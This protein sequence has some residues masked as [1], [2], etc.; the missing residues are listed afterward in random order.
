MLG[1]PAHIGKE[2]NLLEERVRGEVVDE[3]DYLDEYDDF[4]WND[5]ETVIK[6]ALLFMSSR[7][8]A[9]MSG[10]DHTTVKRIRSGRSL[11]TRSSRTRL[12]EVALVLANDDL[13]RLNITVPNDPLV[14]L[15]LFAQA[16]EAGGANPE[17]G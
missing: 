12:F 10:L 6:P 1:R 2:G 8:L 4:A 13:R 5:F 3:Q 14:C 11:G 7:R 9:E 17:Q 15:V 16:N